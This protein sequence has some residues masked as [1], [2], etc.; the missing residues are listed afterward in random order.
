MENLLH[1]FLN[2]L[3]KKTFEEPNGISFEDSYMKN[4]L[5]FLMII[6]NQGISF[7]LLF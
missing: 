3:I 5:Q 6:D 4:P 2:L 7:A 1:Y